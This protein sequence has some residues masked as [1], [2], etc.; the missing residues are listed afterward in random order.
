MYPSSSKMSL[1]FKGRKDINEFNFTGNGEAH[2][3]GGC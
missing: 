2:D 3:C 1:L